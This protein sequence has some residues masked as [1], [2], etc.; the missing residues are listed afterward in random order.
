MGSLLLAGTFINGALASKGWVWGGGSD[1]VQ[2]RT[3]FL[4]AYGDD[5]V[6]NLNLFFNDYGFS[7]NHTHTNYYYNEM[8]FAW[9]AEN[10]TGRFILS[11]D[12]SSLSSETTGYAHLIFTNHI[13]RLSVAIATKEGLTDI[14]RP[15]SKRTNCDQLG[16]TGSGTTGEATWMSFNVYGYNSDYVWDGNGIREAA[17]QLGVS[18]SG[19]AEYLD[20]NDVVHG[21][22]W[23]DAA[24]LENNFPGQ[25]SIVVGESYFNAYGGIDT[26]YQ[27]F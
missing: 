26:Q 15:L 27:S 24:S 3:D 18:S 16:C 23:C 1:T 10:I 4:D 13:E 22:K 12:V 5:F 14:I 6:N 9:S 11:R 2:K 17:A 20:D 8:K 25:N 21:G 19:E 7:Y